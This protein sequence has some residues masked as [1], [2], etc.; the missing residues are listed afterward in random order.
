MLTGTSDAAS[1]AG[2]SFVVPAHGRPEWLSRC[3]ESL[4]AQTRR[5][6]IVVATS[7]PN[8]MLTETAARYGVPLIVN[9]VSAGIAADWNFALGRVHHGWVTLAHQDD[10]YA[11]TYTERCLAA[12][13]QARDSV[14]VFTA[15]SEVKQGTDTEVRNTRVKR[16]LCAVAFAGQ[17]AVRSSFRKRLLLSF[18]NPIPCPA[19]MINRSAAPEFTFA[20]GWKSNLDWVAWLDLARRPGAFVYVRTPLVHRRVHDV[21][22]TVTFLTARAAEDA[23]VLRSLWPAPLAS[24]LTSLYGAGREQVR[25]AQPIRERTEPLV[26]R[27]PGP[28]AL[29]R[30]RASQ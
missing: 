12:A 4:Q 6:P 8:D 30:A 29:T 23:R 10:W 13:S 22:A 26:V 2:H 15:A 14:L 5:S 25:G 7:T 24:I 9:P 18:G 21:A 27:R 20:Q 16:L 28:R 19:V 11:P 3:L 1:G 17:P